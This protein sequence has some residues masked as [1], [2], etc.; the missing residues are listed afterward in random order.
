MGH[1]ITRKEEALIERRH[2]EITLSY[3]KLS[4]ESSSEMLLF[5][6]YLCLSASLVP[7]V[8]QVLCGGR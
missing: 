2:A 4:M 1:R 8:H 5:S 3:R 6:C 7:S